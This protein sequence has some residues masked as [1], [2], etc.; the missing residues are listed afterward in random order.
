MCYSVPASVFRLTVKKVMR[1]SD[2]QHAQGENKIQISQVFIHSGLIS[3]FFFF[4]FFFFSFSSLHLGFHRLM[5]HHCNHPPGTWLYHQLLEGRLR[6]P[7]ATC[8]GELQVAL[9]HVDDQAYLCGGHIR[10][11]SALPKKVM[12]V[13]SELW[14]NVNAPNLC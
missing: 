13:S 2:G 14:A 7:V 6:F 3:F 5:R 4:F 9:Q 8:F 1:T 11:A 12:S 10:R